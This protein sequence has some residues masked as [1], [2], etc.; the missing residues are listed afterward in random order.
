MARPA[1][2]AAKHRAG[3]VDGDAENQRQP[4]QPQDLVDEAGNAGDKEQREQQSPAG[5]QGPII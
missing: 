2:K 4:P 5:H 1:M 3:G